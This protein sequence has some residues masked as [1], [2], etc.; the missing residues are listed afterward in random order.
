MLEVYIHLKLWVKSLR[1]RISRREDP[2]DM[3]VFYILQRLYFILLNLLF[4]RK[5]NKKKFGG[6]KKCLLCFNFL[7]RSSTQHLVVNAH[8]LGSSVL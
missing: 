3:N 8:G 1:L 5:G 4:E 2:G 6:D 7:L